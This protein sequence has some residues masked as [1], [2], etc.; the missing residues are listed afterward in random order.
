MATAPLQL[1]VP[2]NVGADPVSICV[3]FAGATIVH[4][5]AALKRAHAILMHMQ[6]LIVIS[7][8]IPNRV[9]IAK[10]TASVAALIV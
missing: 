3:V 5:S 8:C 7:V 4:V 6:L 10:V 9:V 1:I 2:A